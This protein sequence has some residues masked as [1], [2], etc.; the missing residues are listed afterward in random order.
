MGEITGEG[1]NAIILKMENIFANFYWIFKIYTK[2]CSFW[3][4]DQIHSLNISEV[5]EP[6]KCGYLNARNLLF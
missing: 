5:I 4:K 3:K 6:I 2:F 1:L